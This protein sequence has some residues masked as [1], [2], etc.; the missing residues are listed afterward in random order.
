MVQE[1]ILVWNNYD[2]PPIVADLRILK[3]R[4]QSIDTDHKRS[5]GQGNVFTCVSH[6]VHGGRW[7]PARGGGSLSTGGVCLR[8][9][10]LPSDGGL[11]PGGLPLSGSACRG[12][13]SASREESA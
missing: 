8:E 11:P 5:L 13:V 1:E 3:G 12:C 6:S 2:V 4:L 10:G 9:G 7:P